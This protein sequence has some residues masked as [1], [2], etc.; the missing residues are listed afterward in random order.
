VDVALLMAALLV[1]NNSFVR[2][3]A[4]D[5][6]VH[7]A[8]LEALAAARGAGRPHAE[9]AAVLPTTRTPGM[10]GVYYRTYTTRDATIAVACVSPGMQRAFAAAIG[11]E[12]AGLGRGL[13]DREA[14]DRHYEPLRRQ[15][16]TILASRTTAEWKA[17]FDAKGIP[18]AGVKFAVEILDDP[19]ALAN[20]F[21]HDLAH[22]TVGPVRVLAPPLRLDGDGFAPAP[23][24]AAFG[25]ESRTILAGLGFTED[26]VAGLLSGGV[27]REIP[28]SRETKRG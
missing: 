1:Q 8:T 2:V 11:I 26:E 7:A 16:E 22:P 28:T 17:I 4:A 12:D 20:G 5:G 15:A 21:V 19:Q 3:A 24:T 9:Q 25:S 18:A 14:A 27:S 23:A 6:P 10:V 13:S